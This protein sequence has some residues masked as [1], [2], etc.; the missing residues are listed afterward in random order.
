[1]YAVSAN[2]TFVCIGQKGQLLYMKPSYKYKSYKIRHH[3]DL[4]RLLERGNKVTIF[5]VV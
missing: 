1:M 4:C 3:E 2:Q 5:N